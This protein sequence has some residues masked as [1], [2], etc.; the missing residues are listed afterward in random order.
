MYGFE[1]ALDEHRQGEL[2]MQVFGPAG[3]AAAVEFAAAPAA[4]DERAGEHI[5]ERS[6]RRDP[7][8]AEVKFGIGGQIDI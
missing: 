4:L 3:G 7:T 5:A 1:L 8:P 2:R 6:Q